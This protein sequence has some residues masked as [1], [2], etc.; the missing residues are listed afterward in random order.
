MIRRIPRSTRTDTLFPCTTL[1]RSLH[2]FDL[3]A[4]EAVGLRPL[5]LYLGDLLVVTLD[6]FVDGMQQLPELRLA[7]L[8][9]LH[10]ALVGAFQEM[11]LR[12]VQQLAADLAELG[13]KL[14]LGVLERG[15]LR[16]EGFR[17]EEHTSEL[18]SL[19]RIS[20]DVF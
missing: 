10:H 16:F 17:S 11:A 12:L 18:Q 6:R 13:R 14:F 15:D 19:L 3:A 1:F 8:M 9:R 5:L 2:R 4:Q 7:F 20:Y